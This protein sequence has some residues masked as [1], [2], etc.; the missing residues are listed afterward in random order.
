M[1]FQ[2]EADPI[3][4]LYAGIRLRDALN[5]DRVSAVVAVG[6]VGVAPRIH[7]QPQRNGPDL[8]RS[9]YILVTSSS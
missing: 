3:E 6:D 9:A 7:L 1:P 5:D 4:R 2:A 8:Y